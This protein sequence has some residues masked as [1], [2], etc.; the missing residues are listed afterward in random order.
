MRI[1]MFYLVLVIN[2]Q[3]NEFQNS[4]IYFIP[5]YDTRDF[6]FIFLNFLDEKFQVLENFR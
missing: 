4:I 3:D 1:D 6:K 2:F 5:V